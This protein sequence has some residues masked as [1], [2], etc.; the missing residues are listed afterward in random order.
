MLHVRRCTKEGRANIEAH[1]LRALLENLSYG[2][3][4]SGSHS[5]EYEDG[6]LLGFCT[7]HS[8]SY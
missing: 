5:G 8:V 2:R 1:L 4:N 6:C 7:V 3:E